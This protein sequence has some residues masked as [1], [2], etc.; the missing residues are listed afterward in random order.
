MKTPDVIDGRALTELHLDSLAEYT[1]LRCAYCQ[2]DYLH[3]VRVE[4][5]ERAEDAVNGIH[6]N[7]LHCCATVD[8]NL[9]G[10]PSGRRDGLKIYFACEFC[11]QTSILTIQQHKGQTFLGVQPQ[12]RPR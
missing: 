2:G 8:T 12:E 10:N 4:V 9:E 3:H 6:V 7:V 1:V 11:A 5:F